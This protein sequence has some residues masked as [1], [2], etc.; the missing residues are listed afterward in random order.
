MKRRCPRLSLF[1]I[2]A[3]ALPFLL[4][5]T[6]VSAAAEPAA[7]DPN[8][9]EAICEIGQFIDLNIGLTQT[10]LTLDQLRHFA[11]LQSETS[12]PAEGGGAVH[13][14]VYPG[15]VLRAYVPAAGVVLVERIAVSGQAYKLPFGLRLGADPKAVEKL[16]GP[17]A[18]NAPAAAGQD[19][20]DLP[21]PRG[22]RLG[23]FHH[24]RR[25][26]D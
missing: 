23:S 4:G 20:M 16:L 7:R 24:R 12:K 5:T 26:Q 13:E 19:P 1:L 14:L 2:F 21:E 8:P 6:A 15:L 18:R 3:A 10:P 22:Y 9:C 17:P 11:K 25:H